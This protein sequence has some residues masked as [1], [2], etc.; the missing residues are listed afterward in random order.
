MGSTL[1]DIKRTHAESLSNGIVLVL[2]GAV[3]CLV[4]QLGARGLVLTAETLDR[5][6]ACV[7]FRSFDARDISAKDAFTALKR[8]I[9]I[10]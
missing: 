5:R 2:A 9:V 1:R 7:L 3:P 6:C 8:A 4:G 10:G